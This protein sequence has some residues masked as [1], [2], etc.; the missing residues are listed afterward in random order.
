MRRREFTSLLG[1]AVMLCSS[2]ARAQPSRTYLLGYLALAPVPY[3]IKAL[4][5][6]LRKLGYIEDHNLKVEYRFLSTGGTSA[7]A[8][9]V[10]LVKLGP[11][12]I[13]AVGTAMTI[14]AKRATTTIPIVMTPVADPTRGYRHEPRAS[15]RECHRYHAVW[16]GAWRQA[17][18]R[19]QA[20][21]AGD[22]AHRRAWPRDEPRDQIALV[23][24]GVGGASLCGRGPR[25][26]FRNFRSH[27]AGPCQCCARLG[28]PFV[29]QREGNDHRARCEASSAGNL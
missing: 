21:G 28:R 6:G 5:D 2:R 29:Q 22:R 27:C 8:L 16:F 7:D 13:I 9:A 25:G 3:L 19:V 26:T 18:G 15:R 20:S 1:A 17:R 12:V 10:E 23:V 24:A 11:D 14:A 4:K